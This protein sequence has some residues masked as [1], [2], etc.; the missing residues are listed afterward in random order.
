[1]NLFG[2]MEYAEKIKQSN[3]SNAFHVW[4]REAANCAP[5]AHMKIKRHA[6]HIK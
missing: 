3:I 4:Q 1:M 5:V 2:E 6:K